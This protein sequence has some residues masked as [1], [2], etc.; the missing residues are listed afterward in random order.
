MTIFDLVSQKRSYRF[1]ASD[2]DVLVWEKSITD[3]IK[4][5]SK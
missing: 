5:Y 2:G 4:Q 3:A 1:R